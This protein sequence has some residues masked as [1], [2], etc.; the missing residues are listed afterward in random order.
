MP[1]G[2]HYMETSFGIVKKGN[3]KGKFKL[4]I[5]KVIKCEAS[6]ATDNLLR[7]IAAGAIKK[8]NRLF[9]FERL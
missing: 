1:Q 9:D 4:E 5:N 2:Q 6:Q 8:R 7:E 3:D